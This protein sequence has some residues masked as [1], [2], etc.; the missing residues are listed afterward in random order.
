EGARAF[1]GILNNE[2]LY[3]AGDGAANE[4]GEDG[5]PKGGFI[6]LEVVNHY[7]RG[8]GEEVEQMNADGEA[9]HV[10]DEDEPPVRAGFTM[11]LFPF[12]DGPKDDGCEE[13]GRG[14]YFPFDG[15][16]PEGITERVSE[17]ADS[18]CAENGEGL[19]FIGF[20]GGVGLHDEFS[21]EV[22]DGPEEE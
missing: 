13:G 12:E 7:D 9:H 15:T 11:I 17:G 22:S 14:I 6:P 5:S 21:C 19:V 8:D 18:A 4:E 1:N 3:E 20:G 10:E 16:I 2:D